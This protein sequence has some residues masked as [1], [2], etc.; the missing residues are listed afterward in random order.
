MADIRDVETGVRKPFTDKGQASTNRDLGLI[1]SQIS[2]VEQ[3]GRYRNR[4]IRQKRSNKRR[5]SI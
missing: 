3:A 1:L 4:T 2:R 5:G